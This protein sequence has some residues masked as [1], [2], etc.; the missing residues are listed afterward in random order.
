MRF[1]PH[2]REGKHMVILGAVFKGLGVE[3][4]RKECTRPDCRYYY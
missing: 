1:H 4:E 3:S 2:P